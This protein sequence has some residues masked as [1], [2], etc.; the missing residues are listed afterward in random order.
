MELT[1][2]HIAARLGVSERTV[3][4]WIASGKL[5]AKKIGHYRYQVEESDLNALMVPQVKDMQTQF[6]VIQLE[7]RSLKREVEGL[8]QRINKLE[9]RLDEEHKN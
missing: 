4:R 5:R 8:K 2:T 7:I 1:T 3:Q 9:Q 6:A